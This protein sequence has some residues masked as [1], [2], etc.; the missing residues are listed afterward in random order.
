MNTAEDLF[1]LLMEIQTL[2]RTFHCG[3]LSA[4]E[5]KILSCLFEDTQGMTMG[6]M[7]ELLHCGKSAVS[8]TVAKLEKRGLVERRTSPEDR[9]LVFVGF[10]AQGQSVFQA[11][12]AVI[13]DVLNRIVGDLGEEQSVRLIGLVQAFLESVRRLLR[14]DPEFSYRCK[15]LVGTDA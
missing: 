6:R 4:Q 13:L 11:K 15:S 10:T 12:R 14:E 2:S 8:Q 7:A 5:L 3:D 1:G 9:R